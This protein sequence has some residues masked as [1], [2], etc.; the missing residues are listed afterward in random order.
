MLELGIFLLMF[1]LY[2]L[3]GF[4][5][6]RIKDVVPNAVEVISDKPIGILFSVDKSTSVGDQWLTANS[7][8]TEQLLESKGIERRL[9]SSEQDAGSSEP[10]VFEAVEKAPDGANSMILYY[11]DGRS[12]VLDMPQ[13]FNVAFRSLLTQWLNVILR[14]FFTGQFT[15]ITIGSNPIQQFL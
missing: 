3:W 1:L 12:R 9:L 5:W 4:I 13:D 6:E 14:S 10:W 7:V 11:E 15:H 8:L 2:A